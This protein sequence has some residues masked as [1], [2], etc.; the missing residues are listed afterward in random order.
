MGTP[1]GEALWQGGAAAF[2]WA[3]ERIV[4]ERLPFFDHFFH[5]WLSDDLSYI[6]EEHEKMQWVSW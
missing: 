3:I 4:T 5:F 2:A 6:F 1:N